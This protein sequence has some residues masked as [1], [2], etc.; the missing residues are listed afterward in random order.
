MKII[1]DI[2]DKFSN[3]RLILLAG[4]ELVAKKEPTSDFWLLKE[5][6]CNLCGE[7]CMDEPGTVFGN[8]DEGKCNKLVKYG[9]TWECSAGVDKPYNCLDDPGIND[10]P[11]CSITYK[12]V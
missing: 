8:D 4:V 3:R 10:Y 11:S 6:S 12:K 1:L 5:T 7:C 2:P 9:D